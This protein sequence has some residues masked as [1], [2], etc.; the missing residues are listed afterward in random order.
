[1]LRR[2]LHHLSI[3]WA[4]HLAA[5]Q[6][7]SCGVFFFFLFFLLIDKYKLFLLF[8]LLLS[9][10]KPTLD[11]AF[12]ILLLS[13]QAMLLYLSLVIC[14]C[15]CLLH[16][17]VFALQLSQGFL[18][19]SRWPPAVLA[20]LSCMSGRTVFILWGG[21]PWCLTSSLRFHCPLGQHALGS[22]LLV[23]LTSWGLLSGNLVLL[24]AFV[25]SLHNLTSSIL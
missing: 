17:L 9:S 22:H 12:L 1:M 24:L 19:H 15:F 16:A 6:H 21:C 2:F 4:P 14:S 3:D 25:T 18:V 13:I 11:L 5:G 8:S 10:F 23:P 7:F 20:L